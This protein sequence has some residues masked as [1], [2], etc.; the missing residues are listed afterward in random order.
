MKRLEARS[1][2]TIFMQGA[3]QQGG[4]KQPLQRL[5][6]LLLPWIRPTRPPLEVVSHR[7]M[8]QTNGISIQVELKPWCLIGHR[9]ILTEPGLDTTAQAH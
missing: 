9:R 4:I 6:I 5:E 2:L 8:E 3:F 1:T 7:A